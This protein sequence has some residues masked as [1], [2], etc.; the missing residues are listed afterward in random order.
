LTG[1][2]LFDDDKSLLVGLEDESMDDFEEEENSEDFK[3]NQ[4]TPTESDANK[5]T[6]TPEP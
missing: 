4:Q 3:L 2:E 6:V 5:L 1:D